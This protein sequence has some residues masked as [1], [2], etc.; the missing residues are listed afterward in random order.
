MGGYGSGKY[1]S[2]G[3]KQTVEDGI[4]LNIFKL[5]Q[6][7]II[8]WDTSCSGL[9]TAGSNCVMMYALNDNLLT[10]RYT[11]GNGPHAGRAMGYS[12]RVSV[13]QPNYG[14]QRLWWHCPKC[15]RRCGK[16]Y[17]VPGKLYYL[18]RGCA[19]LTYQSRREMNPAK[20]WRY[21]QN[22]DRQIAK[23]WE[24]LS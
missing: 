18:C 1:Q 9:L 7:K 4:T 17:L 6:Q 10:L 14:G 21:I 12:I 11:F 20:L 22:L 16:L 8:A 2:D 5:Y 15:D 24:K 3:A 23:R 13:T 19:Q